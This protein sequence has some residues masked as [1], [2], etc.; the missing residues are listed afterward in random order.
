MATSFQDTIRMLAEVEADHTG[1]STSFISIVIPVG[2]N[3]QAAWGSRLKKEVGSAK[4]I[5]SRV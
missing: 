5:R 4:N 2:V 3:A 1:S